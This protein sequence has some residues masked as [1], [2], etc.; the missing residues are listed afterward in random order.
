MRS[1]LLFLALT[2]ISF[3]GLKPFAEYEVLVKRF[4][5][6]DTLE[7]DAVD[8]ELKAL[9]ERRE[10][11]NKVRMLFMDTPETHF[12]EKTQGVIGDRAALSLKEILKEGDSVVIKTYDA[13]VDRYGRILATIHKG[14][15]NVNLEQVK[16]GW[17]MPLIYGPSHEDYDAAA[18]AIS[19]ILRNY[20]PAFQSALEAGRGIYSEELRILNQSFPITPHLFRSTVSGKREATWVGDLV[21]GKV[22][23]GENA[24]F[25]PFKRRIFFEPDPKNPKSGVEHWTAVLGELRRRIDAQL[26]ESI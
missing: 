24:E 23:A 13:P 11:K 9:I 25:I 18:K 14:A 6:G 16:R 1:L 3:A 19:T 12:Q 17:A 21:T 2:Q 4:S 26:L 22:I 10:V 15:V 8:P 7:I 5:D 20:L